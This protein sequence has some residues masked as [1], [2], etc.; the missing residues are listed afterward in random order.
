MSSP[1]A[2]KTFQ[3]EAPQGD[4]LPGGFRVLRKS[5]IYALKAFVLYGQ[6][7]LSTKLRFY[8]PLVSLL[9]DPLV[10]S[11]FRLFISIQLFQMG[12]TAIA[13]F[14]SLVVALQNP[15]EAFRFAAHDEEISTPT[16]ARPN[17]VSSS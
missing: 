15:T 9:Y 4:A 5:H 16:V 17:K 12:R 7:V 1:T 14:V 13:V 2:T 10:S 6:S 11:H 8:D 3:R